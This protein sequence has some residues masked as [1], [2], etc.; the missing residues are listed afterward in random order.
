MITILGTSGFIGSN[1]VNKLEQENIDYFAPNRND[2]LT[3]ISLGHIIYCIGMTADFRTKPF[4]TI[5]AHVCKL[6]HVLEDCDFESLTY[7][8]ST[9]L[10]IKSNN[11]GDG[12]KERS[13]VIINALDPEDIF[14]ASKITGELLALNSG[15]ENIK[16]VRLSN[17][18]GFDFGSKNFLTSIIEDAINK[19]EIELF[20][21]SDS[22]KDYISINDV[23]S[24]LI[25]L[26]NKK[27]TGI[28]N[29][30]FGQNTTNE[31]ILEKIKKITGARISYS[32]NARKIIFHSIDIVNLSSVISFK[33]SECIINELPRIISAFKKS[34]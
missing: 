27:I 11:E 31:Q 12:L 7:L 9:R 18:F 4:D 28:F 6:K 16:I 10:Y 3:G 25:L 21:T 34:E 32:K 17:V 8:S 20:T 23:C 33:P 15:R 14:A 1:L 24:S 13:D 5:E 19:G 30:A 26:A 22:A 29:L 2:R